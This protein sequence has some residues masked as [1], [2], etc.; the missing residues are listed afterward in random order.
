MQDDL[1]QEIEDR[2]YN[3]RDVDRVLV[4]NERTKRVAAKILDYLVGTDPYGKTIVF[5]EDIDHAER[6]RSALV[7]EVAARIPAEAQNTSKFVVR[8]TGDSDEGKRALDD[9]IHPEHRYPVIATTS[10]LLT[11]G[12]DAKTTKLIVLDQ[13]IESRFVHALRGIRA[14]EMIEY[15][16]E[17]QRCKFGF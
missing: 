2:V 3:Q 11:T 1:G 9:F 14:A 5:C 12:V 6:M 13:R 17:R 10:K 15:D 16:W 4:L 7:N 8:I